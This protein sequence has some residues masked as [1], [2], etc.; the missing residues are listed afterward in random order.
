MTAETDAMTLNGTPAALGVEERSDEA[1]SAA[2]SVPLKG[3]MEK[4]SS[5]RAAGQS[6]C[7]QPVKVIVV[8]YHAVLVDPI[9]SGEVEDASRD[10]L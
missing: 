4:R 10:L 6:S 7:R 1:P 5:L 3:S 8:G 2:P 9:R